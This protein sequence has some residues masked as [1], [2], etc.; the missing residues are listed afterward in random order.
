ME[1]SQRPKLLCLGMYIFSLQ[2]MLTHQQGNVALKGK[3][4]QS[5]LAFMYYARLA[6]DGNRAS[7]IQSLSCTHTLVEDNPWWRVDLLA[8]HD[9][10]NVTITN[11][12]D[13]CSQRINGAEIRIGNSLLNNGNDNP[14]CVIISSIPGGASVNYNCTMRGRY[15]NLI[16]PGVDKVTT[17]CEVEVY[18]F[19]VP[20]IRMPLL[21]LKFNSSEDLTNSNMRDKV[22]QK[23]GVCENVQ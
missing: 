11:R 17:L 22:L 19:P 13:C 2:W 4:T 12:R 23:V 20:P 18:G 16:I 3:A 9:I 1:N 7:N 14:R 8:V 15:V 6:I 21:R 10:K 5:S